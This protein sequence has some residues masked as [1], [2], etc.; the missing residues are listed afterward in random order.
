[1]SDRK[2]EKIARETSELLSTEPE[3]LQQIIQ[4]FQKEI[5]EIDAEIK[6]L[7]GQ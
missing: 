2:F 5:A 7:K 3:Q 4:K 6:K 1:M